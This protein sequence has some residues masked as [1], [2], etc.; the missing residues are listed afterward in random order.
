MKSKININEVTFP[1]LYKKNTQGKIEQWKIWV[2]KVY[3]RPHYDIV[4]EFGELNG[5]Q[6][7]KTVLVREGKNIGKKNETSVALQAMLDAESKH[8]GMLKKGYVKSLKD[9][10]AGKTDSIIKGGI[11]PMAAHK[12]QDHSH[13]INYPVYVQPKLDGERCVAIYEDGEVT[14]WTRSRKQI[15][16]CPL[17]VHQLETTLRGRTGRMVLDGELYK[18]GLPK[19]ELEALMGA[20]RKQKPSDLSRQVEYHIYDCVIDEPFRTRLVELSEIPDYHP[21]VQFVATLKC[22]SEL[23]VDK[24]YKIY[25]EKGYEGVMVRDPESSYQNK[26]TKALLKYKPRDDA[27]FEITDVLPGDDSTV[28]F[29]CVTKEG[30]TF[31]ATKAGDKVENQKYLKNKKSYIGKMLTV[32]YQGFSGKNN[33]PLFPTAIRIRNEK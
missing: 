14:L 32:Q 5:K 2:G 13:K 23:S 11:V 21:R 15:H 3:G 24:F 8:K 27:E 4:T 18:H 26:R 12:W 33:V 6:Q 28:V 29:K 16:S 19:K 10:K 22:S 1:I 30:N 31:K 17:I 7:I 9:A 25:L 20:V